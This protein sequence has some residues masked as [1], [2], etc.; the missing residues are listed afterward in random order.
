MKKYSKFKI[1]RY[2]VHKC[3]IIMVC[4]I[5][6]KENAGAFKALQEKIV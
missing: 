3:A 1:I 2:N 6:W 5:T 4:V